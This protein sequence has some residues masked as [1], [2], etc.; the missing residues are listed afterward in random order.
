M[1]QKWGGNFKI[2]EGSRFG[3]AI[4]HVVLIVVFKGH[5]HIVLLG[6]IL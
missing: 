6:H 4:A 2:M 1:Q 3:G 5:L